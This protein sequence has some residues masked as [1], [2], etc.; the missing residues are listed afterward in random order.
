MTHKTISYIKSSIRI[1]GYLALAINLTAA[2][3]IL[4]LSEV[5]GIYEEVGE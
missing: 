5:V 3:H 2:V 1:I 4:V